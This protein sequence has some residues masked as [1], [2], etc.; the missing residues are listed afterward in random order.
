VTPDVLAAIISA[1]GSLAV[2]VTALLLCFRGFA[3]IDS[4]FTSIE[5]RFASIERRL[6]QIHSDLQIFYRLLAEHDKRISKLEDG[7]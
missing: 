3:S 4:R 2:A 1:T 6:D 7:R 5:G